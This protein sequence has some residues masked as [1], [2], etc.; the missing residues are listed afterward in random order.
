MGF[1]MQGDRSETWPKGGHTRFYAW[2]VFVLT[3]GLML[4]DYVSRQ[5][6]TPI[7]PFLKHEWSLTDTQLGALVSV[8]A[9]I[10]GVASIP[11]A[12]LADRWGRVKSIT[13]MAGLWGLATIACGL[14]RNY[15]QMLVARGLVGLGE[16]GYGSAGGAIL[17]H[18]FP[19]K[20]HA[21]IV[22]AFLAASLFGSV[23]GVVA[24]GVVST[25]FG[26]RNAFIAAGAAG[27]LLV[28]LYPFVV[29]D[30]K[31][32][33][34]VKPGI[35]GSVGRPMTVG[36]TVRE[37]FVPR[38][39]VFTY[40]ASGCQM[41]ILGVINAWMPSYMSRYYGL[42]PD[43]AAMQAG[44]VVLV[45][46]IGMIVC[47]WSVDRLGQRDLRN[48][49]R[50]PALYAIAACVLLTVAF[51]MPPGPAQY[52]TILAGVFVAGGHTGAAGAVIGDVTHPGLR[53]TAFAVL[54]LGNNLLGLAPGPV[55]VGALSDAWGLRFALGTAPLTC[56]VAAGFFLLAS[57]H[58]GSES[59]RFEEPA[60]SVPEAT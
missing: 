17:M 4:S 24:G 57:R 60:E 32:V 13:A 27:L 15:S 36:E 59:G 31:T 29:R 6:I 39:A 14:S 42:A 49:L 34:L 40:L 50:V 54:V 20:R 5:V 2:V 7:F 55:V 56:L 1:E 3:L 28:A 33:A 51:A 26:W 12:L 38:T 47:G 46:G 11:V 10:V 25:H 22:G 16:A 21:M 8:V 9:L 58:Y 23:A 44:L 48:K 18:V 19:K 41:F 37:L 53:A 43:E 35:D 52:A 30:Y 45:A